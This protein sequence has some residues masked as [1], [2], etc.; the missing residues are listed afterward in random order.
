MH[1]QNYFGIFKNKADVR[2]IYETSKIFLQE[3][4]LI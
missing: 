2:K 4:S 3:L 1:T